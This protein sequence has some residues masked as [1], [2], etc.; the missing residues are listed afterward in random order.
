MTLSIRHGCLLFTSKTKK[1]VM[2]KKLTFKIAEK[3]FIEQGRE[4]IF[5]CEDGFSGWK[6]K[7]KFFDK[8][9]DDFFWSIPKN[10]Y[11]VKS[12][13]PRRT[14]ENRRKTN[15]ERY[16]NTCSLH[17]KEVKKK[18][19]ETWLKN[20]GVDS[21]M[22]SDVIKEK[23]TKNN[24]KKYGVNNV[25]KLESVKSKKRATTMENYGVDHHWKDEKIKKQI[26]KTNLKKYGTKNANSSEEI[27]RK[28]RETFIRKY[29]TSSP[30]G[31]PGNKTKRDASMIK[32][33]GT[34][35]SWLTIDKVVPE[36]GL[37]LKKWYDSKPYPKR[38]YSWVCGSFSGIIEVPLAAAEKLINAPI[39]KTK[40]EILFE[41]LMDITHFNK[42]IPAFKDHDI[43]YRP[44]FKLTESTF[45]NV[46]GLYWHSEHQKDKKYHLDMRK[47][48][49]KR[50]LRLLQFRGD[51]V[52]SKP[53]IVKSIV[54]NNINKNSKKLFARKT[55]CRPVA[56]SEAK[57]FL[58]RNHLMGSMSAKHIG[59]YAKEGEKK[60]VSIMSF[61]QRKNVCKIERFCS[62]IN[63]SVVGGF[64]KL[65]KALEIEYINEN[66]TEIY[67]WVD[68][69]YGTGDHLA[70][71]DFVLEK[72]T[73]GWKW[74][75]GESTYNRLRCRANMDD[76]KL[77]QQEHADELGWYKI[78]DSGQRLWI[79][80]I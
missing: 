72:E 12:S 78:Y 7:S 67:N 31:L 20:Y 49:D 69:R 68:L 57:I 29:G 33:Y 71:K 13:H 3:R 17:G 48:F 23:I 63:T 46:D 39:H 28:K 58:E 1:I 42:T 26:E 55:I 36:L 10:V 24:I 37:T 73:L 80:N 6:K 22:K 41:E 38:S 11:T 70:N 15:I 74:S 59:L 76:R 25:S 27:K 56:Q 77:T 79:K 65:L 45:V 43:K 61:K 32:K 66:I 19:K 8:I 21:P 2:A 35:H 52:R 62:Q 44:D 30:F 14:A 34:T 53:E 16:G 47:E 64:S 75:D 9:I 18:T 40:L 4:D 51:E 54:N 50:N 60:L 5:L